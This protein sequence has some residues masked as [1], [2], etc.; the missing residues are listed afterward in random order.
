MLFWKVETF[1]RL[2]P[3]VGGPTGSLRSPQSY[4]ALT[5]VEKWNTTVSNT[6]SGGQRQRD[7]M[8][9]PKNKVPG[10]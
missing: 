7:K 6:L 10:I 4:P 1:L 2:N 8:Q 5:T 9:A 3:E